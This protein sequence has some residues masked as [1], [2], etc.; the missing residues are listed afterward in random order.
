MTTRT[1]KNA[2]RRDL[3]DSLIFANGKLFESGL[4]EDR[5]A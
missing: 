5:K 1:P 4:S 3:V 2:R